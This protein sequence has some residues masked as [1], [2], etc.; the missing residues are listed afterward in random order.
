MNDP[1]R[2]RRAAASELDQIAELVRHCIAE[3]QP[4][5]GGTMWSVTA[6]RTEPIEERLKLEFADEAKFVVVGDYEGSIVGYAVCELVLAS[7]GRSFARVSDLFTLEGARHVGV[8]EA[9]MDACIEWARAHGAFAIDAAVLPGTRDAKNF[10]E[11]FG[12]TA[13]L[14]TVSKDL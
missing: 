12:L 3:L 10:F 11:G 8:G 7:D 1:W 5:R 6:A 2:A 9:M 14:L 13:R 4:Q